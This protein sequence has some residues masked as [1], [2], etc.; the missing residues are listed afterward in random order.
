MLDFCFTAGLKPLT[1]KCRTTARD[2]VLPLDIH[3]VAQ[4]HTTVEDKLCEAC[5]IT[6]VNMI[7]PLQ[8]LVKY[9][10]AVL[11]SST[12]DKKIKDKLSKVFDYRK[13]SGNSHAH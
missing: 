5:S 8:S 13:L 10:N 2:Q 3:F 1:C 9:D 11:V 7:P 12:K 6:T 4:C